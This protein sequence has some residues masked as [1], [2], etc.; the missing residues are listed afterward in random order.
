MAVPNKHLTHPTG[1]TLTTVTPDI[2]WH[3]Q[4][5]RLPFAILQAYRDGKQ[6]LIP[7]RFL[8]VFS[9]SIMTGFFES[10]TTQ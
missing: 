9:V 5:F 7:Q 3:R 6:Y 8:V 1:C 2:S 4:N 10:I